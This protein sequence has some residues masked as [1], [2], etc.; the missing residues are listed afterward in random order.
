MTIVVI[1]ITKLGA[2]KI[3]MFMKCFTQ[4]KKKTCKFPDEYDYLIS[5]DVRATLALN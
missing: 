2:P 3:L 1:I 5:P 4:T